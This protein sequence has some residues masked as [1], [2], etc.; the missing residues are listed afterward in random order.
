MFR[1]HIAEETVLY[2]S[3]SV[4]Q[5]VLAVF[6]EAVKNFD[7]YSTDSRIK[8]QNNLFAS[9][10]VFQANLEAF[11]REIFGSEFFILKIKSS[12]GSQL[13]EQLKGWVR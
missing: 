3:V 8:R 10:F 13:P 12:F 4:N 6:L 1:F 11:F 9:S 2:K 5:L 7:Q